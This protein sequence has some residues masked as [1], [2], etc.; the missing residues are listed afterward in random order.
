MNLF[1]SH[2][3]FW[4][5]LA[6]L[7]P[8]LV[9]LFSKAKP[10]DREFSSL[11]FLHLIVQRQRRLRRPRDWVLLSLRTLAF[12]ALALAFTLPYFSGKE[13]ETQSRRSVILLVDRSASLSA[14][15]GQSSRLTR[16]GAFAENVVKDLNP[17]DLVNLIWIDAQP[18]VL[19]KEPQPAHGMVARE[20]QRISSAP[21][22]ANVPTTLRLATEQAEKT[23]KSHDTVVYLISDFQTANWKGLKWNE[24]FPAGISIQYVS[25]AQ[26]RQ[27]PN[28]AVSD[29]R[30]IPSTLL[31][32]QQAK[33]RAVLSQWGDS[34]V[35]VTAHL[36]SGGVRDS[37]ICEIPAEGS[38][39]VEFPLEAPIN[40]E[41]C[42][43]TISLDNDA[44]PADNTASR[45]ARIKSTFRCD[46]VASDPKQLGFMGK[47]L[48]TIPFLKTQIASGV[49]QET[50]D[51]VV[52]NSPG[53]DDVKQIESLAGQGSVVL[54][55]PDFSGDN[56]VNTLMGSAR[57]QRINS[58]Y[59]KDEV[60]WDLKRS[61]PD[62]PAFRL[63]RGSST[64]DPLRTHVFQR[65]REG[66][67]PWAKSVAVL[68]SYPDG[69]P[70]L[71][72]RIH[73]KGA[74]LLWNVPIQSRDTSWGSSPLF[75]PFVAE[76]LLAS[77]Q[78]GNTRPL[79]VSGKDYPEWT[80]PSSLD[81]ST[82]FLKNPEGKTQAVQ[83]ISPPGGKRV[84]RSLTPAVPGVYEWK[85]KNTDLTLHTETVDFPSAES[86]LLSLTP[87]ELPPS[88]T[89]MNSSEELV[90]VNRKVE[91]WPWLI[92]FSVFLLLVELFLSGWLATSSTSSNREEEQS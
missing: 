76:V 62:D 8:L 2:P 35:R 9:H 27:L 63:F 32:G 3:V 78:E 25:V 19:F 86:R 71:A 83:C 79:P 90:Q 1:F 36:E 34:P 89:Q 37:R 77:R 54:V 46:A 81:S 69:I 30:I 22:E 84:L 11:S 88:L 57:P 43:V 66:F 40:G 29:L 26:N 91:L 70:A 73:G 20:L 65:L 47:A 5:L 16:A 4:L 6:A 24:L 64:A 61:L 23:A 33:V 55:I 15:D 21:E 80:L 28:T 13:Q 14:A 12:L 42:Q 67:L 56:A 53:V 38:A 87:E 74:I 75:L 59:A 10:K 44:F 52:W 92:G 58:E 17:G 68:A 49:G 85:D 39:I 18:D 41:E 7:I 31:P 50:P 72:R 82:V 48:Q 45:V 51:F 60:G